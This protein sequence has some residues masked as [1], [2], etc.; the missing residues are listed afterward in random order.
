MHGNISDNSH[1]YLYLQPLSNGTEHWPR[2]IC[3]MPDNNR[4]HI[5]MENRNILLIVNVSINWGERPYSKVGNTGNTGRKHSQ[6]LYVSVFI[7]DNTN[8]QSGAVHPS[9]SIH[10]C[11]C[12]HQP[13]QIP[14]LYFLVWPDRDSNPRSTA[15]DIRS[16]IKY[17]GNCLNSSWF[18]HGV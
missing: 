13:Q 4:S 8:S 14:I 18:W 15:L 1:Y 11:C 9:S 16:N 3:K 10:K 7:W 6:E 12:Q 5:F 2:I 17:S